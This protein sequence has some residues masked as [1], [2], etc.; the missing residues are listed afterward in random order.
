MKKTSAPP[1]IGAP[2]TRP[3]SWVQTDRRAHEA[4]ARLIA[5]KPRA[6]ELLHHL[7]AVMGHQNAVVVSQKVL[8]HMMCRSIDTVQRAIKDLVADNWISVVKLHGPGSVSA[9]VVNSRVAWGQAR[10]QLTLSV[11]SA[12]VVADEAD[13][14][15]TLLGSGDLRKIPT[16]FPGEMQLPSGRGEEP[17]SQP[18]IEGLEPDLPAKNPYQAELEKRGQM[19]FE[20]ASDFVDK[21]PGP[22]CIDSPGWA[23]WKDERGVR[24]SSIGSD[25]VDFEDD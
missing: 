3:A 8:A 5:K 14:D 23:V 24:G 15:P 13:Q 12:S 6:A 22:V 10:D 16:L 11:F 2:A 4:W 18:S 1:E 9:Y 25:G 7:V 19:T 21:S 17:P 20:E